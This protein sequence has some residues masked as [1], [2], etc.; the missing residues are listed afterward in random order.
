M[1]SPADIITK[2]MY[3]VKFRYSN[4]PPTN[5][6]KHV[7]RKNNLAIAKNIAAVLVFG[8]AVSYNSNHVISFSLLFI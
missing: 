4:G 7:K 3:I 6:D 5:N 1:Q 2:N 8:V